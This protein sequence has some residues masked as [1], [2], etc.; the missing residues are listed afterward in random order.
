MLAA[1]RG[2][3]VEVETFGQDVARRAG[4][5]GVVLRVADAAGTAGGAV[6]VDLDYSGFAGAYGGDYGSRLTFT[7]YPSCLLSTPEKTECRTGTP[8]RSTNDPRSKRL[9]ADVP[10]TSAV[11]SRATTTGT[12]LVASASASGPGGDYSATSLAPSGSWAAG[13]STGDFGYTLPLNLPVA[14]GGPAPSLAFSYTSSMVDGRTSATN[15]QASW[16]G[17]GWDLNAGG[18][19][20]RTSTACADDP[21]NQGSTQVGD[22]CWKGEEYTVS[23]GGIS[24]KLLRKPD[25]TLRPETD[26]GSRIEHLTGA[27]NG[28]NDGEHWK[29]TA[30][31]GTQYFLGLNR[32]PG[33]SAG[34]PETGSAFTA[35]V[36][37][38][39]NLEPCHQAAFANSWCQQAY[40]WNVDLVVDT[41]GNAMSLHYDR[42]TNHYKRGG[43]NGTKTAYTAAGRLNHIDYGLR[44]TDLFAAA[45]ARVLFEV[46]ERCLPSGAITCDP[47]QLTAANAASWP[48]VP[49]DRVCTAAEAD[50]AGRFSPAFFTTKRLTK[51]RTQSLSGTTH[52]DVDSWALRQEFP[53]TTDGSPA[54][55][56]LS[57]ITRTGHVGGTASL[58]EVTF[59]GVAMHNRVDAEE[60]LLP[61]TRYRLTKVLGEAGG[62][63]EVQYSG[64]D[65]NRVNRM[66]ANPETNTLRCYPVWWT[67]PGD[68]QPRL[69]WFHKYVVTAVTE[70]GRTGGPS[71]VKTQYEYLDGAAWH[72]DSNDEADAAER[73]W[74]EY[75][76]YGRVRTHRGEPN[77]VRT[78]TETVYLRGMDGD[79]LPGGAKR[80]VWVADGDGGTIEDR[81][82]LSGFTRETRLFSGGQ[83]VS[84]A[85]SEPQLIETAVVGADTAYMVRVKS[86]TN[87]SKQADGTWRKTRSSTTYDEWGFA[88]RVDD[89]GDL[90]VT[91]D[92]T[93]SDTTYVR[94][95]SAWVLG[96][97]STV[98][99]IA[100]PCSEWPG[101]AA[102]VVSDVRSSYDGQA[103]G[104]APTQGDLTR[105]ERW[106]GTGYQQISTAEFD[107]YGRTT[108]STDA[109]GGITT[110][111]YTPAT[112]NPTTIA[113]TNRM[114]WVTTSTVDTAR[115]VSTTEVG[116]NGERADAS[117]DP[118]G[119][120]LKVWKPGRAVTDTPNT[121]YS[122][123][124]HNEQPTVIT[125]KSLR[126]NGSYAVSYDLY[127]GLLRLRQ[128]QT[129]GIDGGRLITDNHYDARGAAYKVNGAY[130]NQD[131]PSATLHGVQ[132]NAVPNQTVTEYDDLGR[133]TETIL[134]RFDTELWRTKARYA[135][136]NTFT[137]PPQGGT[138]T[139]VI[140]DARGAVVERRQY[141]APSASGT[142]DGA[143]YDATKFTYD[144]KG[145][146]AKV[147]DALDNQWTYEY[148]VL[149]RKS[150]EV[151]PDRGRSEYT[152]DALD[153]MTTAKDA[154][155]QVL[156]FTYDALGRRTETRTG[157]ATGPKVSEWSYDTLRK[158]LLTSSTRWV[159]TD[160]YTQR[161]DAYDALNRPTQTSVVIPSSEGTLAGTYSYQAGYTGISGNLRS[162]TVPAVGALPQE[163]V[164][165][166][167]NAMDQ[168]DAT[169]G[170]NSYASEHMYTPYGETARVTLGA[171]PKKVWVSS[172]Y[173][174]GTRRLEN[175][176]VKRDTTTQPFVTDRT[177]SYDPNG[178]VLKIADTPADGPVDNQCFTYDHLQRM[179]SAWTPANGDCAA[180]KTVAGLGGA[181]PYWQDYTYDKIGNRLSLTK[182]AASGT[183]TETYAVPASGPTSVRPHAVTSTTRVSGSSTALD[184]YTYDAAG[185]TLTRKIAG[186]TQTL[187]WDAEG[188]LTKATEANGAVSQYLY[189]ADGNRLLRREPTSTTLYLPGQEAIRLTNGAINTKRYYTHAG[190]TV[191]M[192]SNLNG[193]QYFTGDHHGTDDVSITE[194]NNLYVTR[195]YSDPFGNPRGTQPRY[196]PDDKGFVGGI[197]DSSGLTAVGARS[198]DP[199]TG[200]FVTTDPVFETTESFRMNAYG[201]ANNN[202]TTFSD[203]SGERI[204]DC[205]EFHTNCTNGGRLTSPDPVS[206][207]H[208]DAVAAAAKVRANTNHT[209]NTKQQE[210]KQQAAR[211]M[212]MSDTE[213]ARMEKE[214]EE[215]KGFWG[216]MKEELPDIIGDLTGLNDIKGCFTK[217]DLWAC[218]GLI[219]WGKL[220]KLV[221]TA[222]KII[223]IVRKAMAYEDRISAIRQKL[224][225]WRERTLEL[226]KA[227]EE[228]LDT[229]LASCTKHSFPPGTRVLMADGSTKPIEQVH[230]GDHVIATDPATGTSY[231]REVTTT[232]VHD[233]EPTRTELTFTDGSTL[234]GTDWHPVWV[235]DLGTWTPIAEVRSGSWLKTSSG[236]W[237]Q[238]TATRHFTDGGT[239]HDLTVEQT[240]TYHVLAGTSP[241]LVHNCDDLLAEARDAAA[242]AP[243]EAAMTAVARIKG[244]TDPDEW[245]VGYS[246][247]FDAVAPTPEIDLKR[248][249]QTYA[250]D[251]G[252]C[253]EIRACSKVLR[254]NPGA[255][256]R[257]VEFIV[258]GTKTGA[259]EPSCLSCFSTVVMRGATDLGAR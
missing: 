240:H 28:D 199:R 18:F 246:G 196:W 191:A 26:D 87:R 36:Y 239:A 106:D 132:D 49:F 7:R 60:G 82:Q 107:A 122:Y 153:Q 66:P 237:L 232:W 238:V 59:A 173:A 152:Y 65:C 85:I 233:N 62:L 219:P 111:T 186:A 129:P 170:L 30:P 214:V 17:D 83:V 47:A 57:G 71:Q 221:K 40:R 13:G 1:G 171:S 97:A 133:P 27:T 72:Y 90:A 130:Y 37:G 6:S 137:T 136:D 159:G 119:R 217:L 76:G 154:R 34:K 158:G 190:A 101:T 252:N 245:Q 222:G 204:P 53:P 156:A 43:V 216:V 161:V 139:G 102:D 188:H 135:G 4:V 78:T 25:G 201:Y 230:V 95:T 147:V 118:L 21:G 131:P 14:P 75:R 207:A 116:V 15:N 58:P 226:A 174:D 258:V 128:S 223:S 99:L 108:K 143:T 12:L 88:T 144:A 32:L 249:G 168:P 236:T 125:S 5:D 23:L 242:E 79:T 19:I 54:A 67:P 45:P 187:E 91:G 92:E 208:H 100:K 61:L 183:T 172:S 98:K 123:A 257:D 254:D 89:Q 149:G 80:D 24:G 182:R 248:G 247:R 50:C 94:N 105:G 16:V 146:L 29:V 251:A 227:G 52:V 93:C 126:D 55:L 165:H 210:S 169:H 164:V 163:T 175:V 197:K 231:D 145:R 73:T 68:Q 177:Y 189:D 113:T 121:E 211:E 166:D 202:P 203:T 96:L 104:A 22:L 243:N 253:A 176:Q 157:S 151:D 134:K 44:S 109:D 155:G 117:Y 179:T 255:Q 124:Y 110:T 184:E 41:H 11:N 8:I 178:N 224:N 20:E 142:Y 162:Q 148:D 215:D 181:A 194:A 250:G 84:G 195:R 48:D 220:L 46:A 140:K 38:N 39:N 64:A 10:V 160:A 35:P 9:R 56:W 103:F 205:E 81:D 206:Q 229:I 86:V 51:V 228:K 241:L 256:L 259:I 141:H 244:S 31:D 218:A 225:R 120:V 74:S 77:G 235:A 3:A 193:L 127:D 212:G 150:A 114:G 33:W 112:G 69:D 115:G 167:Y 198:Y 234:A 42:E 138:A 192:R 70:D 63:T 200:R 213:L 209:K 185:N 2:G 180:T